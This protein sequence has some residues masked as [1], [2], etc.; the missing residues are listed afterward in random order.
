MKQYLPKIAGLA[1]LLLFFIA[2][3]FAQQTRTREQKDTLMNHS[4]QVV[5]LK[6]KDKKNSKVSVELKDGEVL[7]D[8]KPI[9]DFKSDDLSISR[10]KVNGNTHIYSYNGR[11]GFTTL[12]GLPHTGL[13]IAPSPF[14]SY[15]FNGDMQDLMGNDEWEEESSRHGFLGVT[16]V[17]TKDDA[18]DGAKISTVNKGSAAEKAG[19]KEDD[20]ITK[21]DDKTIEDPSSLSNTIRKY[22]PE[23]KVTV[24]FKRDGKEQKVTATLGKAKTTKAFGYGLNYGGQKDFNFDMAPQVWNMNGQPRLGIRAQDTEDGK[25]VKVLDVDDESAAEK[26]GIKEG[27]IITRFDGKEVNSAGDLATNARESKGKPSVKVDLLRDGKAQTVELKTPRKL[28][29]ADL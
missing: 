15:S 10:Q 23:D 8:G 20:V 18:T 3:G 22:K 11:D 14:R 1:T 5:I 16:T 19:L 28:K 24:T 4:D 13:T 25:G 27:D 29:T 17:R 2:P 9:S 7:I 21:I 26:A 12:E 6:F